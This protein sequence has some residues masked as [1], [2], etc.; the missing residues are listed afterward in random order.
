MA[1]ASIH[2][3]ADAA[4]KMSDKS[5]NVLGQEKTSMTLIEKTNYFLASFSP[6]KTVDKVTFFRLLATMINAGISIVKALNILVEQLENFRMKKIV[7]NLVQKIETGTSL[8][9][10]MLEHPKV[11]SEIL[12]MV[13]AP[14]MI[15]NLQSPS[16]G[17]YC[18][19]LTISLI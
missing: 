18:I 12:F 3:G 14:S 15:K 6:I 1:Q 8:S 17:L 2:I 13:S 10:A 11:F 4:S 5:L 7:G 9:E 16:K 19:C